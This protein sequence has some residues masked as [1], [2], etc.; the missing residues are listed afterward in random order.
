MRTKGVS[1]A[2]QAVPAAGLGQLHNG[3]NCTHRHMRRMPD[4]VHALQQQK[5]WWALCAEYNSE[6]MCYDWL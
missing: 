3:W 1:P 4:T 6:R 2:S 5:Y